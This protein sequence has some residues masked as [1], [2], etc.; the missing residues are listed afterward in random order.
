MTDNPIQIACPHC[1]AIN[2]LPP[3]RLG[4]APGC[5]KCHRP[6]FTGEPVA[7]TSANFDQHAHR[8]ELPLLV[9]F[10]APW[11]GPCKTMAPQFTAAARSLEPQVRLAKLDT[12]AEPALGA[13][14]NVRSIPTMVLL[15]AGNEIARQSGVMGT[16]QIV[17]WAQSQLI[18][19]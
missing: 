4:E 18:R 14:Y 17:G 5:G 11:C 16:H 13:R 3:A 10:W 15:H 2:R 9:D 7:L 19:A 12:E 1:S 8:S 6:L